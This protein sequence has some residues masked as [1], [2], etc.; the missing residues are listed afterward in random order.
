MKIMRRYKNS[1]QIYKGSY[2]WKTRLRDKVWDYCLSIYV[3]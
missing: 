3:V 2:L 1:I